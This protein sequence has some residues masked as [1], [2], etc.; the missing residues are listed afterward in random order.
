VHECMAV[1]EDVGH[2]LMHERSELLAALFGDWLDRLTRSADRSTGTF[3]S[4]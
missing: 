1:V 2:A 3:P 4:R